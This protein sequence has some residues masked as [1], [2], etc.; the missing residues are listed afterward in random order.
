MFKIKRK[1]CLRVLQEAI[2]DTDIAIFVGKTLCN[3]AYTHD[4]DGNFYI[5]DGKAGSFALGVALST[6]K[7]V[8]I[9]CDDSYYLNDMSE[10]AQI[11]VSGC[12]NIFYVIMV[13]NS[14][15]DCGGQPTIFNSMG[16]AKNVPFHMGFFIHNYTNYF[17]IKANPT[18]EI[19][20]MLDNANG[21]II[22]FID[23]DR[24]VN[25]K[26]VDIN[27]NSLEL[28]SRLENFIKKEDVV[29]DDDK[30]IDN[31]IVGKG[32]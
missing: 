27:L 2:L 32:A 24:E 22:V 31:Y 12:K 30:V 29:L 11:A 9:F 6:N 19:K 25:K 4:R 23:V 10:A 14:Y 1:K 5:Y 18:K 17:K 20:T 15:Q 26:I 21:P 8:F 16:E 3:E 13:S 7:R 28:R